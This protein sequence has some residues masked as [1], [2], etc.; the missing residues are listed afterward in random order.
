MYN[1]IRCKVHVF[2][3][4]RVLN[5]AV[6]SNGIKFRQYEFASAELLEQI[7][8]VSILKKDLRIRQNILN[9]YCFPAFN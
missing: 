9:K 7:H 2:N 8:T 1:N 5:F 3:F 6:L 4:S